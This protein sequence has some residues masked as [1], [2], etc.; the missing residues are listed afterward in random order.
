M[1]SEMSGQVADG[2]GVPAAKFRE[3]LGHFCSG[4]T[5]ISSLRDGA[6]AG[7]TCQ[8]FLSL[9]L[10]PARVAFSVGTR[11]AS[12]PAVRDAGSLVIN[13]L[14]AGQEELSD[15][16]ARTGS[17]KWAGVSWSPSPLLKYPVIDG[18]IAYVECDIDDVIA[19]GDHLLVVALVR[20]LDVHAASSTGDRRPLLFYQGR[21]SRLHT[22]AAAESSAR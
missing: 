3:V 15:T 16:F 22:P 1:K 9:S 12:F 17:D 13:V 21:Y 20:H 5:V 18:V 7:L 8:S 11:S 4:V 14:S 10:D 2:E 19:A 6:P